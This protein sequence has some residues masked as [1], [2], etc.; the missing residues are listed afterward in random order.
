MI[1]FVGNDIDIMTSGVV[2]HL[3]LIAL[4]ILILRMTSVGISRGPMAKVC[5]SARSVTRST[6]C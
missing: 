5:L 4:H 1:R 6:A 3:L 2:Y